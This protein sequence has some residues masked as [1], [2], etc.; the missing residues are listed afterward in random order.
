[1]TQPGVVTHI[2][3]Q[4]LDPEVHSIRVLVENEEG[5]HLAGELP[6]QV[7]LNAS[8]TDITLS[9]TS[10]IENAGSNFVVGTLLA[11]DPDSDES[12]TFSLPTGLNNNSLFNISG[13][14][15]RANSSFDFELSAS[16]T[17]SV[18]VSDSMGNT[19]DKPITIHVTDVNEAPQ[20]ISLSHAT[21]SLPENTNTVLP[22]KVAEIV[23][24]DDAL[25]ATNSHSAGRMGPALRLTGPLC[26]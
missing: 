23:V 17:V 13:S 7:R 21:T 14:Q 18:R 19:F 5:R 22:L 20:S 3:R 6:L 2:Y 1:M 8:P 11:T 16:L 9:N 25:V 15:L 10:V 26:D 12:F 4:T 24:N